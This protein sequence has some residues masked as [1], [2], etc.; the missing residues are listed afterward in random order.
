MP[1]V[2]N[3]EVMKRS[4]IKRKTPLKRGKKPER[5]PKGA[6]TLE[7]LLGEGKVQRASTFTAKPKPM[8]KRRPTTGPTQMDV[9]RK[10]W[11]AS[12]KKCCEVC[13]TGIASMHPI[14]FSHLLPKGSYR[15]YKLDE[16]NLVIK[17][18]GCHQ[19]WHDQGPERL[20]LRPEWQGVCRRY[21]ELKMEANGL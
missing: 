5:I 9:F 6:T 18:A 16:R 21:Y 15:R 14:N 10:M 7:R 8:R 19:A 12:E 20:M 4:E 3:P 13:G 11:D 17:C 1:F 2:A